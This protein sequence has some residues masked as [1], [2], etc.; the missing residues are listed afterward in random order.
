[1]KEIAVVFPGQGSQY[2]GM[3]EKQYNNYKMVREIYE[4]ASDILGFDLFK[5][6]TQGSSDEITKTSNA[7][8]AILV[9]SYASFKIYMQEIGEVPLI[10]AGHSLGEISA[11]VCSGAIDFLDGVKIARQRGII[12]E[13]V[14]A[15][16]KGGMSA[17]KDIDKEELKQI[18]EQES[19]NEQVAW[20][21]NYN[22]P[23]QFVVSGH[24]EALNRIKDR[25]SM[26]KGK[27]TELKVAGPFHTPL[28]QGAVEGFSDELKKYK[29]NEFKFPILSNVT[30]DV[31]RDKESISSNLTR[32]LVSPVRWDVNMNYILEQGIKYIVEVGP[33]KVLKN[34]A[35]QYS[36]IG[37]AYAFDLESDRKK[38]YDL[39]SILYQ[40]EEKIFCDTIKQCCTM[41]IST[42]NYNW[43]EEEYSRSVDKN[44]K[45]IQQTIHTMNK[46]Q[47]TITIEDVEDAIMALK[48]LLEGKKLDAEEVDK[49]VAQII[50]TNGVKKYLN[51]LN[52]TI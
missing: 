4:A 6:C 11:L 46:N 29:F 45:K 7:Q 22:S 17:V 44:Y 3:G 21:A 49:R 10:G 37:Q 25:V 48:V 40:K 2:I 23:N 1:M 19:T 36:D 18:C 31:Y 12:M 28:M 34:I 26:L 33:K 32:Q 14:M 9:A 16:V 15:N 24:V 27:M 39:N 47:K 20:I 52:D 13:N 30:G 41:A 50:D 35:M 5:L 43:N 42:R 8:P 51:K 38:L